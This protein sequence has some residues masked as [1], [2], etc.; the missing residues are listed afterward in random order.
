M[1]IRLLR[2]LVFCFVLSLALT[3]A[4]GQTKTWV[5]PYPGYWNTA[6]NW[7]P[8]GVPGL[9]DD[10]VIYHQFGD[11]V[12]LNSGT[13]TINSLTLGGSYVY[14]VSSLLAGDGT[15]NL[16][17]TGSL[18]IGQTG[19]LE[20]QAGDV[21]NQYG[22]I[23]NSHFLNLGFV[24][25][26]PSAQ[27]NILNNDQITTLYSG[28]FFDIE[29]TLTPSYFTSL[30]TIQSGAA[31]ALLNGQIFAFNPLGG[32]TV[33]NNGVLSV[34]NGT[35]LFIYNNV[36]NNGTIQTFGGNSH[37]TI[38]NTLTNNRSVYGGSFEIGTNDIVR[39]FSL[40]NDSQVVVDSG[41]TLTV[42][43]VLYNGTLNNSSALSELDLLGANT[44]VNV[45]MLNNNGLVEI[46][47]GATLFLDFQPNGI[48]SIPV[49]SQFVL[50]GGCY[51]G[52]NNAAPSCFSKLGTVAG[53]LVLNTPGST[54]TDTVTLNISGY[55]EVANG[56]TLNLPAGSNLVGGGV[57][58]IND[59]G[60]T[61][62][63]IGGTLTNLGGQII[64]N[65]P[66]A[67]LN[68][69]SIVNG[70][71]LSLPEGSFVHVANGFY[72][73][74]AGTL[75]EAIGAGG[76]S[77]LVTADGQVMLA[78][79]LDVMLDPGFYPAIGTSYKF[80]LFD[81]GELSGT[82]D[83]IENR[84][85]NHGTEGWLIIYDNADGYVE[86]EAVPS[87]E[88]SGLM[89]LGTGILGAIGRIRRKWLSG[90]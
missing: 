14:G 90:S 89:L 45:D 85:F 53:T 77:I 25:V 55:V 79:T 52:N 11:I 24:H 12:T 69:G 8:T 49:G 35:Q 63:N 31:L 2:A 81:P 87:P 57:L 21:I 46:R 5:G 4:N 23:P 7:S 86:L 80:L 47:S 9:T 26:G 27:L 71:M 60:P 37:L 36:V 82:F 48:T 16:S 65:G 42:H 62:V 22:S 73:L 41:G 76:Y 13:A 15:T 1:S 51:A 70:G 88:P 78:G 30:D 39:V 34:G 3:P 83:S 28:A 75:G 72:Q 59:P 67:V 38:Y 56:T 74:A 58:S 40:T 32:G 54:I 64:V 17:I 33:T 29:G 20:L 84:Y 10:V 6:A 18:T 68:A 43:D 19:D 66:Q 44:V 61:T 50:E